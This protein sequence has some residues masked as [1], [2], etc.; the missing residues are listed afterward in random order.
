MTNPIVNALRTEWEYLGKRRRTFILYLSFFVIA[1]TV[2]LLTPYVIG[3]VFNSIQQ[4]ITSS[5][6]LNALLLRITLLLVITLIFW[7]FH[8]VGRVLEV[9]T[10]FFVK[11]NYIND[12]LRIVLKLPIKWHKD[13]HSG[14]TI[15]KINR[16]SGALEDFSSQMTYQLVYAFMNFFGSLTI[17]FLFDWKM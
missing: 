10:G 17:I 12:K 11:K 3:T 2:G 15:D 1:G 14:D 5:E 9:T 7:L 6:D 16:A 13:T 4:T 8:G